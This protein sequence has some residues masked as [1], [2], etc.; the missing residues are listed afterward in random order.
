MGFEI[1]FKKMLPSKSALSKFHGFRETV[2]LRQQFCIKSNKQAE[3]A[4]SVSINFGEGLA[5][6]LFIRTAV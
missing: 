5:L 3:N 6:P 2:Y 1:W 4:V